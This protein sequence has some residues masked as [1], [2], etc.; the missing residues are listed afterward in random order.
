MNRVLFSLDLKFVDKK[1][2]NEI[3]GVNFACRGHRR[4]EFTPFRT[5]FLWQKWGSIFVGGNI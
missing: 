3:E 5:S 2:E 1:V 4:L